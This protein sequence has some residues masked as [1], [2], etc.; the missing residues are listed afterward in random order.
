MK[1]SSVYIL[2]TGAINNLIYR[3]HILT[4]VDKDN[5]SVHFAGP[6]S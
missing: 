1:D 5:G 2:A 4:H 6:L 3:N